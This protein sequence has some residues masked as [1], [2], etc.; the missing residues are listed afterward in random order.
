MIARNG[1]VIERF[2]VDNDTPSARLSATSLETVLSS[3]ADIIVFMPMRLCSKARTIL[4]M[5]AALA[6]PSG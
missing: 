1:S 6:P 5:L 3:I 4:P 2:T